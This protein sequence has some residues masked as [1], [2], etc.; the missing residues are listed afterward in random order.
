MS[1]RNRF[2]A[3]LPALC[4]SASLG[5]VRPAAAQYTLTDLG[6]D[7]KPI[8]LNNKG[9]VLGLVGSSLYLTLN[10]VRQF[11]SN[12]TAD[13][14][15]YLDYQPVLNQKGQVADID[16]NGNLFL[17]TNGS[18]QTI[19]AKQYA[20]GIVGLNDNSELVWNEQDSVSAPNLVY[21]YQNGAISNLGHHQAYQVNNAGWITGNGEIFLNGVWQT[22]PNY[23]GPVQKTYPQSVSRRVLNNNGQML[24]SNAETIRDGLGYIT[25]VVTVGIY[26]IYTHSADDFVKYD[27][28]QSIGPATI[29]GFN[30]KGDFVGTFYAAGASSSNQSAGFGYIQGKYHQF[31]YINPVPAFPDVYY[32]RTLALNNKGQT[33]WGSL[34]GYNLYSPTVDQ[35]TGLPFFLNL[36]YLVP[37]NDIGQ[38]V[39]SS[40]RTSYLATP[41][42]ALPADSVSGVV[43]LDYE[44][45]NANA[46]SVAFEFRDA[47]SG[48]ALFTKTASVDSS[49]AFTVSGVA[50]GS[51][52][53]W[54]K[55]PK[56]LAQIV[57]VTKTSGAATGVSVFLPGGDANNDNSVDAS[58][59]GVLVGAY[60][61][62]A[63]IPGSGYDATADFNGDGFVDASDFGILVNNYGAVGAP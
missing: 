55:S 5:L 50:A 19:V 4:L 31:G 10:G 60:G 2:A 13:S 54:V 29:T 9:Q 17:F 62:N 42:A 21:A 53:V 22:P 3:C 20:I 45:T 34:N 32:N 41:N 44:A 15:G 30:D 7:F 27:F 49:G 37:F 48:Q 46:Q 57:S 33:L 40:G 28:P 58:D 18:K 24:Y 47:T 38:I 35:T 63:S 23:P 61:S 1:H 59:F 26:D 12:V 16:N 8:A 36:P 11:V 56:N 39:Y 6:S 43:S 52:I 25:G 51:Y 14:Y